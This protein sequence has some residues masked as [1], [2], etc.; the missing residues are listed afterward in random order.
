MYDADKCEKKKNGGDKAVNLAQTINA[1]EEGE[2]E[3]MGFMGTD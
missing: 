3:E 1:N 2:S